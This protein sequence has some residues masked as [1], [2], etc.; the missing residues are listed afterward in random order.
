MN[1]TRL[2]GGHP[3]PISSY[4]RRASPMS[5]P[6]GR[7]L[8]QSCA[9]NGGGEVR[10]TGRNGARHQSVVSDSYSI[11]RRSTG[12]SSRIR[13]LFMKSRPM[14]AYSIGIAITAKLLIAMCSV[15]AAPSDR[16]SD[17]RPEHQ[18][19]R[20]AGWKSAEAPTPRPAAPGQEVESAPESIRASTV[21]TNE[22]WDTR[23]STTGAGG[24]NC[25][26]PMRL[27]YAGI[28]G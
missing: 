24:R 9:G 12:P 18:P 23:R 28:Y 27:R 20:R 15:R 8:N 25:T 1:R 4:A 3:R 11:V 19:L 22:P 26:E 6:S 14:I 10:V 17:S 7:I 5:R 13:Y 21:S 16:Q 2:F